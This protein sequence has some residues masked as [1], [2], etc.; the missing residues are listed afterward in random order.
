MKKI[1]I[2]LLLLVPIILYI[3]F[4]F[5]PYQ[6]NPANWQ[7]ELRSLFVWMLFSIESFVISVIIIYEL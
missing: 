5:V 3:L 7:E 6:F 4:A 1:L 2:L